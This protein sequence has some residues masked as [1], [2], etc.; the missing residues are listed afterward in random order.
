MTDEAGEIQELRDVRTPVG[1]AE[2]ARRLRPASDHV[3]LRIIFVRLRLERDR[4]VQVRVRS[5]ELK[6]KRRRA[7]VHRLVVEVILVQEA[8]VLAEVLLK[9]ITVG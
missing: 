3:A 4:N 1:V 6:D 8:G 2:V 9:E 5:Q 7:C